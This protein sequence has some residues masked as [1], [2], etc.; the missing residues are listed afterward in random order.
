[1]QTLSKKCHNGAGAWYQTNKLY[2]QY[3]FIRSIYYCVHNKIEIYYML[4]CEYAIF[5]YFTKYAKS[6][7]YSEFGSWSVVR[8]L[9]CPWSHLSE[10]WGLTCPGSHLSGVSLV[11]SLTCGGFHSSGCSLSFSYYVYQTVS[12]RYCYCSILICY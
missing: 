9:T 1:M 8:G 2:H 10:V 12:R 3:P 7:R 11:R 4:H 6:M 5:L